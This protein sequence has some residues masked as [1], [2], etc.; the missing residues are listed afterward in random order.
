MGRMG[1]EYLRRRALYE[2]ARIGVNAVWVPEGH[3]ID[4][5]W[6]WRSD[7][8]DSEVEVAEAVLTLTREVPEPECIGWVGASTVRYRTPRRKE[9]RSGE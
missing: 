2:M 7:V 1:E 3:G 9:A 5:G 8:R 6:V 4:Q